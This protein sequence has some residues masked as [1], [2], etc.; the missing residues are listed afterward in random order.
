MKNTALKFLAMVLMAA[1]SIP[2]MADSSGPKEGSRL[3]AFGVKKV[4]GAEDDGTEI[5]K[6][7]CYR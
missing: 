6:T 1:I 4:A 2:A 7:L 5:G 3:G